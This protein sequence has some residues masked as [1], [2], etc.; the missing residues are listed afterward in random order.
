MRV[1]ENVNDLLHSIIV[2]IVIKNELDVK[3]SYFTNKRDF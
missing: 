1:G 3:G 2:V